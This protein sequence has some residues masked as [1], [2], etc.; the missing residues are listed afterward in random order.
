M[1][2][3]LCKYD[4]VIAKLRLNAEQLA[5][6]V[7]GC[8]AG[9][10]RISELGQKLKAQY[11]QARRAKHKVSFDLTVKKIERHHAEDQAEI[12]QIREKQ[13]QTAQRLSNFVRKVRQE[14]QR[15]PAKNAQTAGIRR[16]DLFRRF[17]TMEWTV[18][19]HL[20]SSFFEL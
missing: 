13:E 2:E 11:Q 8:I 5:R 3:D 15:G 7:S 10:R 18:I 16:L 14:L 12:D 17:R 19:D 9:D 6:E 20:K 1:A 4:E